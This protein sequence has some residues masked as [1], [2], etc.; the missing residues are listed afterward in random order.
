MVADV[1]MWRQL[2]FH[3]NSS[4]KN[5]TKSGPE[6]LLP[7]HISFSTTTATA[8][9]IHTLLGLLSRGRSQN[10]ISSFNVTKVRE[11]SLHPLENPDVHRRNIRQHCHLYLLV[12]F[13]IQRCCTSIEEANI[14]LTDNFICVGENDQMLATANVSGSIDVLFHDTCRFCLV[15]VPSP[16][17]SIISPSGKTPT[18]KKIGLFGEDEQ[19]NTIHRPTQKERPRGL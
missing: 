13:S 18:Q 15:A 3:C 14:C 1:T 6:P 8:V 5:R 9:S 19:K 12:K 16:Q 10:N 7:N 11:L 2:P 17:A 4:K